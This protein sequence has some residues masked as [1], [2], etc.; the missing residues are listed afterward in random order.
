MIQPMLFLT[1]KEFFIS[2]YSITHV[3]YLN[4][5]FNLPDIAKRS[6]SVHIWYSDFRTCMDLMA[7]SRK[8]TY[9][10]NFVTIS[11]KNIYADTRET[12]IRALD[13]NDFDP[14]VTMQ[15]SLLLTELCKPQI[16][17]QFIAYIA[18]WQ[19]I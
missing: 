12:R 10:D 8:R 14:I 18:N 13:S 1:Y 15:I 7:F 16:E 4:L 5:E 17:S 9:F 2:T 3:Y 6:S 11:T 19:R